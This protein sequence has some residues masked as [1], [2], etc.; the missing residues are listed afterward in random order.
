MQP[1][2]SRSNR[3]EQQFLAALRAVFI[4]AQVEGDSG[5]INDLMRIKAGVFP[6]LR[7]DMDAAC[8]PFAPVFATNCSTSSTPKTSTWPRRS[9][10]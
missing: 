7:K 10:A 6:R 8:Q 3:Y 5:Y 1:A 4:G 2:M 9:P